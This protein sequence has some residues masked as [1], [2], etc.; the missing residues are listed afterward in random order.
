MKTF[1]PAL[2]AY[3]L[4]VALLGM[5]TMMLSNGFTATALSVFDP[6]LLETFGWSRA[7]LKLRDVLTFWLSAF[8]APLVG[9]LVDRFNPKYLLIFGLSLLSLGLAGYA[10]VAD[11]RVPALIMV[12]AVADCAIFAVFGIF[13]LRTLLPR[14]PALPL[15]AVVIAVA[16]GALWALDW[17]LAARAI[18]QVYLI[19]IMF[20][21]V[22]TCAGGTVVI[23]LVS[24]W[25][26]ARRGLAIGIALVGTSL[27]TA[28]LPPLNAFLIADQDWRYAMRVNAVLPILGAAVVLLAI[29]GLPA[30][31]NTGRG[32]EPEPRTGVSFREALRTRAF[33]AIAASG[34]LTYAAIFGFLQHLVLHMTKGLGYA[35]SEAANAFFLFSVLAMVAKLASGAI[36][37][38]FDRHR[39][40]MCCLTVMFAGTLLLASMRAPLLMPA[41]VAIAIGW[42]GLFTLYNMLAVSNF[43][44]KEIGRIIG[45]LIFFESVGIGVGSW[46]TARLFDRFG[47]YRI[48]F[49]L[50]GAM[51]AVSLIAG[52]Q[53]RMKAH[54][55]G[56]DAPPAPPAP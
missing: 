43:G 24:A 42:G 29:R 51:L 47:D 53:T 3:P 38:R 10:A 12:I 23:V 55:P 54:G 9:I 16:A 8:L 27:G 4:I 15:A 20:A 19:H 37:D 34:F 49:A 32:A 26:E 48:A 14:A 40:F 36:A 5:L 7:D 17:T 11:G 44:L 28:L 56:R 13:A 31:S 52:S 33:W 35:L 25:N 18:N 39:V 1:T 50:I 22:I 6:A 46:V 45:S 41:V 30:G 21:V 2:P